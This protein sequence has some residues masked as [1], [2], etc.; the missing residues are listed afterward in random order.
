MSLRRSI[1]CSGV[2]LLS[3]RLLTAQTAAAPAT[4]LT[5]ERLRTLGDSLAPAS[6]RTAQLGRGSVYT[7]ALTHRDSSGTLEDHR[8][9]TDVFVVASGSATLLTGGVAEGAKETS[10]GEWR[11]GTA[12]GATRAS[13]GVGDVV[14]IPA[15]T[16]HQ[17]LLGPGER[18]SYLAFKLAAR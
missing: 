16:P 4:I 2:L 6:S 3:A 9:W 8:D 7:Y 1:V 15:G 12:R 13:I 5:A 10:P 17:M 18:I 11:G 14:V